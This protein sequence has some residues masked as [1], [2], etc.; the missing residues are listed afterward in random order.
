M[1]PMAAFPENLSGVTFTQPVLLLEVDHAGRWIGFNAAQNDVYLKKRE[2][3]LNNCP[4]GSYD[5]VLKSAGLF[6]GSFSD[7]PLLSASNKSTETEVAL[8]NLRLTQSFV[9][10]F[11]DKHLKHAK[12][13]LLDG[14]QNRA[15]ATVK[16]YGR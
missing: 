11:L 3:Q 7:Y 6:H 2:E 16:R 13:P 4:T 9:L 12:E 8:H 10:A 15:E 1:P 14:G 5:V